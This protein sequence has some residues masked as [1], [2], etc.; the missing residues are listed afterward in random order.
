MEL[1]RTHTQLR[2]PNTREHVID[3]YDNNGR[4]NNND[5]LKQ[6]AKNCIVES[7]TFQLYDH[8]KTKNIYKLELREK[9]LLPIPRKEIRAR[10]R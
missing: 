1:E 2:D 5:N 6:Y 10:L 4:D 3:N 8:C 9:V 7:A